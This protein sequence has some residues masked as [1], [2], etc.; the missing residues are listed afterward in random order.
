M[1]S[2]RITPSATSLALLGIAALGLCLR[3]LGAEQVFRGQNVVFQGY[4][5]Y[6]HA[7]R[8]LYSLV[9]FPAVL[10]RD[11]LL[12]HP[13]GSAVPWP[14]LYDLLVAAVAKLLGGDEPTLERVAALLPPLL[15]VASLIPAYCIG[16][17]LA[18]RSV[19]LFAALLVATLDA[20][21]A[22]SR[23]GFADH[24]AAGGLL[25]MLLLQATLAVADRRGPSPARA[26][27]GL[28]AA[29]VALVLTIPGSVLTLAVTE[30][31]LMAATVLEP[32][33]SRRAWL[34]R[35][36]AAS[37]L[38]TAAFLLPL[39]ASAA[40]TADYGINP[41]YFTTFHP[42][43]FGCIGVLH[44]LLALLERGFG[45]GRAWRRATWL[46]ACGGGLALL[47]LAVSDDLRGGL[48]YGL[49]FLSGTHAAGDRVLEERPLLAYHGAFDLN[50]AVRLFGFAA[51]LL[52]L[53]PLQ[54]ARA[55]RDAS[56]RPALGIFAAFFLCFGGLSL[57]ALRFVND[58]AGAA[59]VGLALLGVAALR[60]AA[61]RLARLP[62]AARAALCVA[63]LALLLAPTVSV[64]AS[65]V[66]RLARAHSG[67]PIA[68]SLEASMFRFAREVRA[69]T[70][71]TAGFFDP[72]EPPEYGIFA[73]SG[74]G[75]HLHYVARRATAADNF[76]PVIGLDDRNFLLSDRVFRYRVPFRAVLA[77]RRLNTPYV[78]STDFDW[79]DA[80]VFL[81]RLHR[82][83]ASARDE[84]PA[85]PQLRLLTESLPS[86]RGGSRFKLFE[87]VK[88]AVLQIEAAPETSVE[89]RVRLRTNSGRRFVWSNRGVADAEG[90]ARLRV[91]YSTGDP[92]APTYATGPVKVFLERG[93]RTVHVR[94][95]DVREGRTI[96]VGRDDD[97]PRSDR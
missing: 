80:D 90:R 28:V 37:A 30:T 65:R 56:L 95:V 89:A 9:H 20:H 44:V 11:P 85:I 5:A 1:S 78:V 70:P 26:W 25:G 86:G 48:E 84:R 16:R 66:A 3:L 68:D 21:V 15:G 8:A 93:V 52:P 42:L 7:R 59:A 73:W 87:L 57:S 39:A 81:N 51:L 13:H 77:L 10:Q 71:E 38:A 14:P 22:A 19:G 4:D 43:L 12:N 45:A 94:E 6:Y 24:H 92:V 72:D 62:R 79:P 27:L 32:E 53:V 31:G 82:D 91:P 67:A 69:V 50:F 64:H 46:A 54:L 88:G 74:I 41:N 61:P 96:P 63:A 36:G 34:R 97:P 49:R 47:L 40:T 23:V 33:P 2:R 17:R 76:G 83:D 35:A 58:F 60:A 29:R 75:H 55:L 18:G